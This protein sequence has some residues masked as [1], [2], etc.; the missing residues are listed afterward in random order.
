MDGGNGRAVFTHSPKSPRV[1]DAAEA[2]RTR[3]ISAGGHEQQLPVLIIAIGLWKIPDRTLR[4]IRTAA[5]YDR[6]AGVFVLE[7]VG[8]L[9]NVADEV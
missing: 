5:T 1:R 3:A 8:P 9:P 4:L 7:F 6:N 2:N